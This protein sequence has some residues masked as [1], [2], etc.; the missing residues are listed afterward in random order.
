M[1]RMETDLLS[2]MARSKLS[3][4]LLKK[5]VSNKANLFIQ[6]SHVPVTLETI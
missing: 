3:Y 1:I 5:E 2:S 6:V 4:E